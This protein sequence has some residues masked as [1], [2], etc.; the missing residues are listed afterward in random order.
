M[1]QSPPWS[2]RPPSS[3]G[4]R[5]QVVRR[6]RT[7]ATLAAFE[8]FLG[9]L[10]FSGGHV[11]GRVGILLA[12]LA[13]CTEQLGVA[14]RSLSQADLLARPGGMNPKGTAAGGLFDFRRNFI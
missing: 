6:L 8:S 7:V 9:F 3:A 13:R 14:A 1:R 4:W 10:R 12:M 2:A 11:G 5:S